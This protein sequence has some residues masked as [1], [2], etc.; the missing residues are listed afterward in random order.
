MQTRG[1]Q[2]NDLE[3]RQ[4]SA[5]AIRRSCGSALQRVRHRTDGSGALSQHRPMPT[6][7]ETPCLGSR[8]T[9]Q[10]EPGMGATLEACHA[11]PAD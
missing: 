8:A 9:P 10:S 3:I 11:I 1:R 6:P 2:I 5:P 7:A 4:Q